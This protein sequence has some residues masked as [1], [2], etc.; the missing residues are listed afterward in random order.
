MSRSSTFTVTLSVAPGFK[1]PVLPKPQSWIADFSTP[2]SVYGAC[3][4]I[5]T[6]SFPVYVSEVL[7]TFTVN[8]A[9]LSDQST[10]AE[11]ISCVNV[12]YEI[13]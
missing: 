10:S 8:D 3:A 7:V 9:R 5:C 11:V 2:P 6:T 12:A 13:P 1:S 4:Y